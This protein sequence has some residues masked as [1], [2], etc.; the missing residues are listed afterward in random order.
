MLTVQSATDTNGKAVPNLV[1]GNFEVNGQPRTAAAAAGQENGK[2]GATENNGVLDCTIACGFGTDQGTYQFTV[3]APGYVTQTVSTNAV[4]SAQSG[5]N[6]DAD[7]CP[8][9]V[10]DDGGSKIAL[11]LTSQPAAQ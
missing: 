2:Y 11:T 7:G 1:L 4:Y 10:T 9:N 5:V 3:S 6:D 8:S